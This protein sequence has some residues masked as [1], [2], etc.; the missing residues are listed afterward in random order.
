MQIAFFIT[1]DKDG[2]CVMRG[3]WP[4][5]WI[6]RYTKHHASTYTLKM[7]DSYNMDHVVH[8]YDVLIFHKQHPEFIALAEYAKSYGKIVVYDAD[9]YDGEL[10]GSHYVEHFFLDLKVKPEDLFPFADGYTLGSG[11]LL[12]YFDGAVIPN[13]FDL[14]PIVK[15]PYFDGFTKVSW[16]GGTNHFRDI[17]MLLKLGVLQELCNTL[18]VDFHFYGMGTIN[19]ERK[20][21]VGSIF[22]GKA[23][24]ITQYIHN[25]YGD[26]SFTIAPLIQDEFNNNRSTLKLVEA[27]FAQCTC[28]ASDV[29]TYRDYQGDVTLVNNTPDEWYD[30]LHYAITNPE[31]TKQRGVNNSI[32]AEQFYNAKTLTEKRITYFEELCTRSKSTATN[33]IS[34][35]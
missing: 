23:S 24:Q 4:A 14:P 27:G 1:N 19:S 11:S 18:P 6:N 26:A 12:K 25:L 16:G 17:E 20:F 3:L 21:N 9:D 32:H 2:S 10:Y 5:L 7:F 22:T 34:R 31:E 28:I 35:Y 29:E 30:A 15:R 8:K 13:G 33:G